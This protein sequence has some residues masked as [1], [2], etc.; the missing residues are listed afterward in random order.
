MLQLLCVLGF[1]WC[2]RQ[3]F[4]YF[5]FQ[6]IQ[7]S[8]STLTLKRIPK[9]SHKKMKLHSSVAVMYLWS[10]IIIIIIRVRKQKKLGINLHVGWNQ[11]NMNLILTYN[12][13][14]SRPL[15]SVSQY[16]K[17][18]DGFSFAKVWQHTACGMNLIHSID[19]FV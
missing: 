6:R 15:W 7:N 3:E 1:L 10:W 5:R 19:F 17:A 9:V 4:K 12:V 16:W 11:F 8:C 18:I 13:I 2:W 14:S